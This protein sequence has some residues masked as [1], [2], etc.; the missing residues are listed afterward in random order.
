[1]VIRNIHKVPVISYKTLA[2][3]QKCLD[4]NNRQ[5]TALSVSLD[6]N[7]SIQNIYLDYDRYA[8]RLLS[9]ELIP[10]PKEFDP[11]E[12][13]CYAIFDNSIFP[14]KLFNK[15][16]NFFYKLV[17]TSFRPILRISATQMHK[18][19]FLDFLETLKLT[20]IILDA[21]TGLGYSAIIASK[22]ATKVVTVE[23]DSVVL[24]I[25]SYNPHS[26]ELFE[27]PVIEI[28]EG[29]ITTVIKNY[30]NH[31]FDNI[32]QDG[33]M[34]KSSGNFFSQEHCYELYRVLKQ[35]GR[36]IFYLPQH[37]KSKG[38]DFGGEHLLRLQKAGF[39]IILRDIERSYALL[40]K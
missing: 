39:L 10:F 36:L 19:P 5:V 12:R 27:T 16:K 29:D 23:W 14:L 22:T 9:R 30:A 3:I 4:A 13:I 2:L 38:R 11:D 35:G 20:G 21:G 25:A 40:Q 32:I 24:D 7:L 6:L 34:P 8:F 17:P 33:G 26:R 15:E 31:N 37:G 28:I 18:K 1:M